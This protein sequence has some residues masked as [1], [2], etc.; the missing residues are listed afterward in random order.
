MPANNHGCPMERIKL[1]ISFWVEKPFDLGTTRVHALGH[2]AFG[3]ALRLHRLGYL[4]DQA[5][6]ECNF[7]RLFVGALFF[8]EI[9]ERRTNMPTAHFSTSFFRLRA[10]SISESGVFRDFLTKPLSSTIFPS[11]RQ[12]KTRAIPSRMLLRTSKS[13]SPSGRQTGIPTGQ[14]CSTV[15][16]SAPRILRSATERDLSQSRAGS[17]PELVR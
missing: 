10:K 1:H 4:P 12:N 14:P 17:A 11:C 3:D 15:A 6:P 2:H 16:I 8:Q 13:P 7:M 5:A 9:V